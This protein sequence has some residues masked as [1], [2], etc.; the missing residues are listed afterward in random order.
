MNRRGFFG[1][2]MGVL[3]GST[4]VPTEAQQWQGPGGLKIKKSALSGMRRGNTWY[5]TGTRAHVEDIEWAIRQIVGDLGYGER[6]PTIIIEGID[7][8]YPRG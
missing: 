5:I 4:V 6:I 8:I 1:T 7:I 3:L 2:L